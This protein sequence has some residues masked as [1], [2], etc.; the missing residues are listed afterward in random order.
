M[1]VDLPKVRKIV[2]DLDDE[3]APRTVAS[4][5]DCLPLEVGINL[6]GE[7]L[8]TDETPISVGQENSK[9]LVERM[10]VAYWPPGKAICLFFG[11]TP[12]GN[13]GEIRPYSSVNVLG[14][15][16]ETE[17]NFIKKIHAGTRAKFNLCATL[18]S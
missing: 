1:A 3:A 5:L 12:I 10:D 18:K 11:P 14:K 8:Y 7:E 2:L 4:F 13:E 9:S 15:I 17:G 16:R 6:W